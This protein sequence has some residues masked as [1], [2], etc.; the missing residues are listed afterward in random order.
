MLRRKH[1]KFRVPVLGT[2]PPDQALEA[3]EKAIGHHPWYAPAYS[4]ITNLAYVNEGDVTLQ[5]N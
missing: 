4:H 5:S 3:F 1:M 2:G